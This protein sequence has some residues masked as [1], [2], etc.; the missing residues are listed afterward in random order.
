MSF[1]T[2][3]QELPGV[4]IVVFTGDL[5]IASEGDATAAL[6]AALG[7]D[8]VLVAD[9]REL[10][11]LD[12]TGVRVLLGAD[13]QAKE[14]GVRFG[15]ARGDGMVRRLLEVTRIDQ[16]FPVVDDPVELTRDPAASG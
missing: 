8:G 14:R 5:D 9:L 10:A 1:G 6:E 2:R 16:R 7:D 11:F 12:S 15:V 3:T 13:L 4:R